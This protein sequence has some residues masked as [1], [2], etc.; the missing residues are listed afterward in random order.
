MFGWEWAGRRAGRKNLGVEGRGLVVVAVAG[1][2]VA[3]RR[4]T[5]KCRRYRCGNTFVNMRC[6]FYQESGNLAH[7]WCA[8]VQSQ[9]SPDGATP[10][11]LVQTI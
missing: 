5:W 9:R 11:R 6:N 8:R 2:V 7:R 1:G 4:L 3:V 10:A